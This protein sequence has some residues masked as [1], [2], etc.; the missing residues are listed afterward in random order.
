LRITE[1]IDAGQGQLNIDVNLPID[2][3]FFDGAMFVKIYVNNSQ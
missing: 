3:N 2:T 1:T